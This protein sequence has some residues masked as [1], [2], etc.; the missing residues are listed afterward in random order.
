MIDTHATKDLLKK[1]IKE[2]NAKEISL[3]L[4]DL[5]APDIAAIFEDLDDEEQHL[6]YDLMDNEKSAEV[7][8]EIDEDERKHFLKGLSTQEIAD[9]IIN[10]IDSDDA[11]D[12]ISELPEHQQSEVIKHLDDEEHAQSIVDLLRYDE[13]EAG[14]LMATELVKVNQ[15]LSIIAAVKEMRKQAE[16]LDEVYSIYV[17]DDHDKLLGLLSLKKLLTTASSTKV[18]EVYNPKIRSV[19]DTDTAEEVARFMQKYDLFEVPVVDARGNLV[20]RITIDDV[21][22]FI[23]EE[24]EKDYQLASGISRDVDSTDTIFSLTKAR[25]PWLF[26]G[27][28]GGLIGSQVLQ[29]NQNALQTVPALMFFVPLI[30]ATAGNIGVQAS[31]II[32]QGLA[33]DTLGKDTF[34]TLI[35][36]VSVSAASGV[37][38]AMI[39]LSFNLFINHHEMMVSIAISISLLA[40][41]LVAA[42]I[43][44][45]VPIVLNKNKID[46]AIATGPFITTSNDILGVLIYFGIAKMLLHI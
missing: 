34:K 21:I 25:L 39:I 6:V 28:V 8:L 10:E 23:T 27:M 43:G 5:E 11:A 22:D 41:I 7:L 46:P 45:I 2:K 35:K 20:G 12:I 33:N 26:I 30:A 38:L 36:E 44:T 16:D 13:D 3:L 15:N 29:G 18:S 17:V 37:I 19:M 40:V 32:V 14:G 42:V 31:A 4:S 9:E 24:A 1:F